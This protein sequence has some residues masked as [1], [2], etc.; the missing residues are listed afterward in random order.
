MDAAIPLVYQ[1]T[2][3]SE[4]P[5]RQRY[6]HWLMPMLSCCEAPSPSPR[7]RRDFHGR[8]LSLVAGTSELH[9]MQSD[10]FDGIHS[11]RSIQR[12]DHDDELALVYLLQ[13]RVLARHEDEADLAVGAG[14]FLLLDSRRPKHIC[15]RQPRFVQV[16][17]PR[18]E[19]QA[20]LG[21]APLNQIS[22]AISQ[23]GLA[24]LLASQ[25]SQ[26]SELSNRLTPRERLDF[27]DVTESL[28]TSVVKN[29]CLHGEW[30]D[31]GHHRLRG[32]YAAAQLHMRANLGDPALNGAA[33]AAALGCS[34]T[35]LYRAFA[36]QGL[37]VAAYLR[38]LRLRKA[39][40]LLQK[41]AAGCSIADIAARC[42]FVDHAG[43]SRLYRQHFGVRPRDV[44]QG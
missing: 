43:F 3:S 16:N 30:R 6:E 17:L 27:L 26:F 10:D 36:E 23:A 21:D 44:R 12:S 15:F 18:A 34:R 25:L 28:A 39:R 33:I 14:R 37:G 9:D 4:L 31:D 35:T 19:L 5:A 7:Q 38:D 2:V 32:L 1:A 11:K 29:V 22:R 20:V 13:G 8:V 41:A 42:G 24:G 40:R